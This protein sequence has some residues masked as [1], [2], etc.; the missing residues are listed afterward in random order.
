ME[1]SFVASSDQVP[2]S[3][4]HEGFAPPLEGRFWYDTLE[5]SGLEGQFEFS[6]AVV[7]SAGRALAVAPCFVHNVPIALVA[8]APVARG[9]NLLAKLVPRIGY[10]R[11]FFIGS[12]CSDEG[13]IGLGRGVALPEILDPLAAAVRTRAKA[14]GAAMIVF[15]DF[16]AA[17]LPALAGSTGLAGFVPTVSYP[18]CVVSLPPGGKDAYYRSL[19]SN[20]RHNLLKKLRRSR[21]ALDLET[22]V[23]ARPS[24][25][26][27]HELFPLFLQTYARGKTKF[28]RLDLRFFAAVREHPQSAFI[29][30]REKSSGTVVAFML[31]F[32]LGER[33]INKFIGIDYRRGERAF[34]YFRLLDAAVDRAYAV[35]AKEL[36]SGQTG[37]RA[38]A[39]TGHRLVP[40][41]NV[42]HHAN[43]LIHAVFRRI[44]RS[45][46][47]RTLDEEIQF[48]REARNPGAG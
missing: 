17:T 4:W 43:P 3:L 20:Q 46:T 27:L 36:Q 22:S 29:L 33:V 42:F 30:L 1:V 47:W 6:Y 14:S 16:P 25:A 19:T 48:F 31:V 24:D 23:V 45:V 44:G 12:P 39:D 7:R 41:H 8:P 26:E 9:L 15:K 5:K 40:L 35:G 34:L 28:E 10:Q 11:T 2:E 21:E 32:Q 37:Y 13:S 18:G 38:K